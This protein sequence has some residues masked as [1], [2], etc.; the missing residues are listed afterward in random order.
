MAKSMAAGSVVAARGHGV[1]RGGER[2]LA[3]VR[4]LLAVL[5]IAGCAAAPRPRVD[6]AGQLPDHRYVVTGEVGRLVSDDA[7]FAAIA[8]PLRGD[9]ERDLAQH[10]IRE[11]TLL[12]DRLFMLALLDALDGRWREAVAGLDRIAEIE[13]R[14]ADRVMTGLTIRVWADAVPHGDDPEAFRAA[15]E[16]KLAA[17]PIELVRGQLE[18]L[19]TM[20]QVFTPEVC[21]RLVDEMIG[22]EVTGGAVSLAQLQA[23]VFQRYAAV[24]LAPVGAVIDQVLGARGIAARQ[25]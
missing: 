21:R 2:I 16:R 5:L 22:P 18:L 24:R 6:R 12:K 15:L 11:P 14:P 1:A 7:A 9:L 3:G 25:E 23:I 19:R 17:M 13:T 10:D 8:R 4:S 20:G